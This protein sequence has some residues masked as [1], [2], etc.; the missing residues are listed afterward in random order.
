MWIMIT[1]ITCTLF[2]MG[3]ILNVFLNITKGHR[4]RI[5]D[6]LNKGR[7]IKDYLMIDKKDKQTGILYWKNVWWQKKLKVGEPPKD[8]TDIGEKGKRY[9]EAYRLSEDEFVWITD[10]GISVLV[11]EKT[12][13]LVAYNVEDGGKAGK[14]IDSFSPFTATQRQTLINQHIKADEISKKRWS[15]SEIA[16]MVS[17]GAMAMVIIIAVVF[18][19]DIFQGYNEVQQTHVAIAKEFAEITKNQAIISQGLGIKVEGVS[20]TPATQKSNVIVKGNEAAPT[21]PLG[22]L[23]RLE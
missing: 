7:Y 16:G 6:P 18:A 15:P 2:L 11:D 22:V 17:V 3:L 20:T 1:L 13:Q 8:A 23:A 9:V 10:K 21:D 5:R 19:Q 14:K 4:L 12:G